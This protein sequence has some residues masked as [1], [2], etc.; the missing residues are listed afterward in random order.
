MRIEHVA[1]VAMDEERANAAPVLHARVGQVGVDTLVVQHTPVDQHVVEVTLNRRRRTTDE[2]A[3]VAMDV[4]HIVVLPHAAVQE[5][6]AV[7]D[8]AG[9]RSIV[10]QRVL[11][12]LFAGL[13]EPES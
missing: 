5:G 12:A 10:V 11:A 3:P 4:A 7:A 2:I 13:E 9:Q 1:L 8:R 6:H